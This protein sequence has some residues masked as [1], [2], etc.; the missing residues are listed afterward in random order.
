M[1]LR[2]HPQ[3]SY[4]GTATWPP[5]WRCISTK[6]EEIAEGE[7]GV[8]HS[9]RGWSNKI[10]LRIEHDAEIYEACLRFENKEFCSSVYSL[11]KVLHGYPIDFI[12]GRDI[13]RTPSPAALPVDDLAPIKAPAIRYPRVGYPV[14]SRRVKYSRK[15]STKRRAKHAPLKLEVGPYTERTG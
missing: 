12:A 9:V 3:M 1:K 6:E 5:L 2:D 15:Q 10:V 7:I 14:H 4:K 13:R 8:L 11:L